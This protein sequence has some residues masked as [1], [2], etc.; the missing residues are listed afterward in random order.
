MIFEPARAVIHDGSEYE[1]VVTTPFVTV[2]ALPVSVPIKVPEK[3]LLPVN[4]FVLYIFGIV[5]EA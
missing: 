5:V 2:S 1:P 4:T 3:V